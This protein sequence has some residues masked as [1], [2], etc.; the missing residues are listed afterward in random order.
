MAKYKV[1][2][3][4][5]DSYGNTKELPAGD[6]DVDFTELSSEDIEKIENALPLDNYWHKSEEELATDQEVKDAVN[7]ATANTVKYSSFKRK[8]NTEG[9]GK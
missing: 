8:T 3:R 2:I 7:E 9:T 6:I 5:K 1:W 4:V